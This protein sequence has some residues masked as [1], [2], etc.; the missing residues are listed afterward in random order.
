MQVQSALLFETPE[1]IYERVFREIRPRTAPPG[2]RVEFRRFANANS[3]IRLE[4]GTLFVRMADI[5]E[6]APAPIQE[7]L[8]YLLLGKLYRKPVP[9]TY[10]LRYRRWLNSGP[11]RRQLQV[12][13]K[14]RGRKM[15]AAPQ[16]AVYD[17][18]ALFDEL[19]LRFFHG[20]MARPAL[21][22]SRQASRT[23]LGHYDPSHH[24][25]ILSRILDQPEVPRIAVEYV[26]Y[27][28]MLHLK[29]PVE[30]RGPRRCVHTAEFRAAER[31]FPGL[32]EAKR[33]LKALC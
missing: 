25:I 18:E 29:F 32:E 24:T 3:F 8:A 6:G 10:S 20:L 9:E 13:R 22:W 33:A 19:N 28:E 4:N 26:L 5:F 2:V 11:V 16:G 14:V 21:G 15:L 30:H 23:M 31:E 17:L 7:A 12:V 27:H 1:Q